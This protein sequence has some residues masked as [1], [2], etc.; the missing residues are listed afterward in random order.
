MNDYKLLDTSGKTI[1]MGNR[2]QVFGYVKHHVPDVAI[3]LS[4]PK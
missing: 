4:A 2:D 1:V 3:E